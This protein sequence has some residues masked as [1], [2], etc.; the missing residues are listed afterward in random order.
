MKQSVIDKR[1]AACGAST[2]CQHIAAKARHD[3][4]TGLQTKR[5]CQKYVTLMYINP[6]VIYTGGICKI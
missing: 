5:F 6:I 3:A 2:T 1:R 4:A